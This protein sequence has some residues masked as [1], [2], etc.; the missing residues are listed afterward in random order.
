M[1]CI[2]QC[3][4]KN[5]KQHKLLFNA[6]KMFLMSTSPLYQYFVGTGSTFF[7]LFLKVEHVKM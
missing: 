1:Y 5:I 2:S 4:F 7:P 6:N 3:S